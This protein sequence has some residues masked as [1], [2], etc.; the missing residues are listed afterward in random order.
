VRGVIFAGVLLALLSGAFD[1]EVVNVRTADGLDESSF[2]EMPLKVL[3]DFAIGPMSFGLVG[4][5]YAHMVTVSLG[6]P[7]PRNPFQKKTPVQV[8][9][10]QKGDSRL[11]SL[12]QRRP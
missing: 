3:Q 1:F 7:S 4:R 5:V 10:Q 6:T 11:H 8:K 2:A 9:R 12:P